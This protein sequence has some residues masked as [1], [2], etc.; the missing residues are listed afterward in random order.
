MASIEDIV[1]ATKALTFPEADTGD[2]AEV[3]QNVVDVCPDL[4]PNEKGE[5]LRLLSKCADCFASLSKE[6]LKL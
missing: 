2:E 3:R 5:L 6:A 4:S 1:E